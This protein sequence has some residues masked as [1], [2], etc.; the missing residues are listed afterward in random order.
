MPSLAE[1]RGYDRWARR[2]LPISLTV[3]GV[4]VVGVIAGAVVTHRS[5]GI[6]QITLSAG[7]TVVAALEH[8]VTSA[9]ADV[10]DRVTLRTMDS[11]AV[12]GQTV[13]PPG[14]VVQ[15]EVTHVRDGGR[16]AGAPELTLR[17]TELDAG[18]GTAPISARPVQLRGKSDAAESAAEIGGG[19]VVGG[20]VGGVLG[21]G[22]GALAGAVL[23]GGA[24]TAVAVATS[25]G[26]IV[27][28][29]G[30]RLSVRLVEPVTISYRTAGP[31]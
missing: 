5:K 13:I 18:A 30:Q 4:G 2:L 23:G 26:H 3:L 8:S 6:E 17:F 22:S 27:L 11:V 20:I 25:G 9:S 28:P 1:E 29:A 10:G 12:H 24:G 16:V 7:T 31:G 19:A 14:V 15:G 21:G